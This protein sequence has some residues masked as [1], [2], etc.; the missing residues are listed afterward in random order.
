MVQK[1]RKRGF[2]LLEVLVVLGIGAIVLAFVAGIGFVL[3]RGSKTESEYQVMSAVA[4]DVVR[5]FSTLPNY[6]GLNNA[7]M[8]ASEA[9]S[10]DRIVDQTN[11]LI[12]HPFDDNGRIYLGYNG[13]NPR[14]WVL[15]YQN[16]P[17]SVCI[18]LTKRF[19]PDNLSSL[20]ITTTAITPAANGAT[21]LPGSGAILANDPNFVSLTNTAC[22]QATN[23]H[24]AWVLR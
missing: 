12:S 17:A 5:K 19:R 1:R 20:Y 21:T 3:M 16:L 8:I 10:K 9:I 4:Q 23:V 22:S 11:S 14:Q 7:M 6:T 15:I 24:I 2:T 18:E 13:A